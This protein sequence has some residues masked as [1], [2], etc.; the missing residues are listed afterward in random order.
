[1]TGHKPAN[2]LNVFFTHQLRI[3]I[4]KNKALQED[5]PKMLQNQERN[6][7]NFER[8]KMRN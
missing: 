4:K 5:N 6:F 3:L 1:M 7:N 2:Q 8:N